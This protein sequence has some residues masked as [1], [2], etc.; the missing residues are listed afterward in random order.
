MTTIL[1]VLAI[2]VGTFMTYSSK[3]IDGSEHPEVKE[4]LMLFGILIAWGAAIF[5]ISPMLSD[6]P[7]TPYQCEL[8]FVQQF[9]EDECRGI[10]EAGYEEYLQSIEPY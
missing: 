8:E 2:V 10:S 6:E 9:G 4:G 5:I 7:E 3:F 1:L